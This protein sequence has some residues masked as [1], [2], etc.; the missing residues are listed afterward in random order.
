MDL[1]APVAGGG[2][3]APAGGMGGNVDLLSGGLDDL[4]LGATPAAAAPRPTTDQ[5]LDD[6]LGV[7]TGVST[8]TCFIPPMKEWLSAANG[9]GLE[10]KGTF[11][12]RGGRIMMDM[13]LT[14]KAMQNMSEF[15]LQLNSNSFGLVPEQPLNVPALVA[16]KSIDVSMPLT[17]KKESVMKMEPLT[18][19][20]V[21]IKNNFGVFYF[22]CLVPLHVFFC[23]ARQDG[24]QRVFVDLEEHSG[25]KRGPVHAGRLR[26]QRR[27]R[28]H[29]DG[30]KQRVHGGQEEGGRTR[31]GLPVAQVHQRTLGSGRTQN[32][33]GKPLHRACHQ[34]SG[35]G[36]HQGDLRSLQ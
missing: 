31:H 19:L 14:N 11:A 25:G 8:T 28:L 20:Q 23:R 6:I 29:Q 21:A 12:R 35:V 10:I 7:G 4:A 22:A 15:G 5:L 24:T 17:N 34:I 16:N 2:A 13:T 36:C 18:N 30:A 3:A 9:K 1:G 27:R 26:V 33:A 32:Q